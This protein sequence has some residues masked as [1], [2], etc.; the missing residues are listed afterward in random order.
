MVRALTEYD[1]RG[2]RT[3]IAFCRDLIASPEFAAGDFDTTYVERVLEQDG[4]KRAPIDPLEE[5][6]A[7]AAAMWEMNKS[8]IKDSATT[9]DIA[10]VVPTFTSAKP[11]ESIWAQR[12]RLESVR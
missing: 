2:I 4:T 1:V 9:T 10:P 7:I 12:A 6:A 5:V 8:G 11:A 3:T